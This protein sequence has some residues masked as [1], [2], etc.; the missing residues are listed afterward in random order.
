MPRPHRCRRV[1]SE[2]TAFYF[3]PTGIPLHDLEELSLT[4]DEFEA[5]RL[6][7][8]EGFYQEAAAEQM[9]I[10]RPTFSRLIAEARRKVAEFLVR[11]TALRIEGGT[12]SMDK[13][14]LETHPNQGRSPEEQRIG[15]P[16]RRCRCRRERLYRISPK[17][18]SNRSESAGTQGE[19]R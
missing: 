15:R 7:D 18:D 19:N 11:G 5:L 2:P 9:G 1:A 16:R 10:S 13:T 17:S 4:L 12:I 14:N 3:K 6:A 8:L